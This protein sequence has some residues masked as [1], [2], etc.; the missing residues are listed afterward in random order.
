MLEILMYFYAHCGFSASAALHSKRSLRFLMTIA[1]EV[2][3][4][5]G[6][7]TTVF[8]D[9]VFDGCEKLFMSRVERGVALGQHHFFEF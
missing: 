6:M 9:V 4:V 5:L 1:R 8:F 2:S 3:P 7:F